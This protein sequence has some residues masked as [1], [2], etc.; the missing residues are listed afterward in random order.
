MDSVY[1]RRLSKESRYRKKIMKESSSYGRSRLKDF[2]DTTSY[3]KHSEGRSRSDSYSSRDRKIIM[4]SPVRGSR[5]IRDIINDKRRS[6][7]LG[8]RCS[9]DIKYKVKTSVKD[10][11]GVRKED[12][13][14]RYKKLHFKSRSDEFYE[15]INGRIESRRRSVK[16]Y[17]H[18]NE[19]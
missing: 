11:L 17:C 8:D 18:P 1:E 10:R 12:K 9:A 5:T 6:R 13:Q 14:E 16:E 3:N 2:K 7:K 4:I 15:T 19:T